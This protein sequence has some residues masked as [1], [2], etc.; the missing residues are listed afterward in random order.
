MYGIF[1]ILYHEP[2]SKHIARQFMMD[3]NIAY[4]KEPVGRK[5]GCFD[6][7][8]KFGRRNVVRI[9][10]KKAEL[11][12]GHSLHCTIKGGGDKFRRH[13]GT[14]YPDFLKS[15][16]VHTKNTYECV[17]A[18]KT[19]PDRIAYIQSQILKYHRNQVSNSHRQ[20]MYAPSPHYT[21]RIP[22][23][24]L[25]KEPSDHPQDFHDNET[26]VTPE[27]KSKMSTPQE[28][29]NSRMDVSTDNSRNKELIEKLVQD[30]DQRLNEAIQ[31]ANEKLFNKLKM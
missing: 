18:R 26:L 10:N 19:Q 28:H 24:P 16:A 1:D 8:V 3:N 29:D 27:E 25:T 31:T 21:H 7:V 5:K 6:T 23:L 11:S 14:F 13:P 22:T 12:H 20:T 4:S 30:N 9:M 2:W 15:G 17:V